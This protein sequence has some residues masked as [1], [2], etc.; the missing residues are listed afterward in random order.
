MK[1]FLIIF[2]ELQTNLII[3]DFSFC[4]VKTLSNIKRATLML[5]VSF[6]LKGISAIPFTF[7]TLEI[8]S[9]I[10]GKD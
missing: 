6:C 4:E 2:E 9:K 1:L 8:N 5:R 7:E 10:V 3:N